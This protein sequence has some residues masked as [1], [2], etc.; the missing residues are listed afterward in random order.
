VNLQ[1]LR[2]LP[3]VFVAAILIAAGASLAEETHDFDRKE[4][5][6]NRSPF[7]PVCRGLP[8]ARP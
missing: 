4:I 8:A 7:G 5:I 3:G 2:T 6:I 1:R